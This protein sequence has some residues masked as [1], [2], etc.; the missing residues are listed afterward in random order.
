[1]NF[2]SQH[3]NI[4]AL[5]N[6]LHGLLATENIRCLKIGGEAAT[7]SSATDCNKTSNTIIFFKE[8]YSQL[9]NMCNL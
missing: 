4:R 3:E 6:L 7:N 9:D 5:K 8:R 2:L 1:M